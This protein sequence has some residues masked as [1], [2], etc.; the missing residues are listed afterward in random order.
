MGSLTL[1]P[2]EDKLH[3]K[4]D[5]HGWKMSLDLTLEDKEVLDHVR[6]NI[7]APPSNA[8]DAAK[9]KWSKGEFKARKIIRDFIDKILVAYVSDLTISKEIYDRLV[10]LC[11]VNDAN[12]VLFFRNKLKEIKKGKDESMQA[13]F[14]R[15]S[16]IRN[17]LLSIGETIIDRE[18]TLTTLGGL[19]SEWYV[20][21][22]TLLNNNVIPGLQELMARC[23][24]EETRVEAQEMPM[25][26]GPPATFSS[27]AK[28]RNNSGTKTKR[29]AGPKGGRK[30]LC[31]ICDKAGHYA[32]ECPHRND[33]H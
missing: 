6:G 5:Y 15:I 29:K 21:R 25:P 23:I 18:M 20:F 1:F 33:S 32:R 7:V 30:G 27:H 2:A 8:S 3:E 28:K 19:P 14:L 31:Y 26:K 22:T 4:F 12:Q 16:V 17:N 13:Y 10:S 11:K 24:Q 9:C